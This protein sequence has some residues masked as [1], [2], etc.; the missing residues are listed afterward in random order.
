[1]N[2]LRSI[3]M[4]VIVLT[5]GSTLA[6]AATYYLAADG[7]DK[8]P[9]TQDSP[10]ATLRYAATRAKPG[11]TVK[12]KAGT[13]QQINQ[14]TACRGTA[15]QPITFA[16]E[17]GTVTLDG[18]QPI[19]DWRP[20]GANRYSTEVG[21]KIIY[22]VWAGDRLL[23]GPHFRE[24]FDKVAKPTK[25]TLRRG[26]CLIEDGRLYVRLFDN[27]DP[28]R[29][30]M[31]VSI[32]HCVLMQSTEHT[33]WRGIGTAWGLNG[34]KLEAGSAHNLIVDAELHHHGQGILE[35]SKPDAV[36][37]QNTFQR[38]DIHHVGLTKFE[39]GIYTN[40][41]RP[42]IL[43]CRFH[44]I[45]GAGIHAYPG[46]REGI[47][48]GNIFTDPL[49]LY[50]PE[51]FATEQA[52]EPTGHYTAFVCWGKGEHRVSNNLIAGPFGTGISVRSSRNQIVHN[53]IVLEQ[54]TGIFV[55][56]K[57]AVNSLRNNIIQTAG[58]YLTEALPEEL[59]Y[60]GYFGGKGWAGTETT[61][62]TLADLQK[63]GKEAHGLV[64]DPQFVDPAKGN[65][66]LKPGSLMRGAGTP[67]TPGARV[68][69]GTR[70]E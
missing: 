41:V 21:K 66:R 50:T 68:D 10:W 32:G 36:C 14:I 8:N 51:Q 48:D 31:R 63:A 29:V 22:L 39:H 18:S 64:A 19:G 3:A 24:P 70:A 56:G 30:T 52:P 28:S 55:A 11:D 17:G 58:L 57:H 2:V 16:A 69:L 61:Y 12:V 49:P 37:Q 45:S 33:V 4:A 60:N 35:V 65:H 27:G 67:D 7:N 25:D 34:Y 1:M 26:Q 6:T 46:P 20:D 43:N 54:G 9:G 47:F 53:T 44:H 59:D 42:R 23:L 5:L 40:G 38:L 15:E 13:Y 62:A